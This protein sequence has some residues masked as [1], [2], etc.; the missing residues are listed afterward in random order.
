LSIGHLLFGESWMVPMLSVCRQMSR[1][2]YTIKV[3]IIST[4]GRLWG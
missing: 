2:D 3:L 1:Q 4:D